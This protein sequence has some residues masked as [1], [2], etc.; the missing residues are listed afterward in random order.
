MKTS[1][2]SLIFT[3]TSF[4][5]LYAQVQQ[6]W[7]QRYNGPGNSEDR[8]NHIV[9]DLSGN[10]Y[11]TGFSIGSGTA[12]DIAT[13]KYNSA[14]VQQWV[15]RYNGQG[16]GWDV[17]Y[18]IAVDR[19]G[20]VY[21]TGASEGIGTFD[22]YVTI[23]YNSDG[24][25]QWVQ[26][27]NGPGNDWDHAYRIGLDLFGNVY[28]TGRSIGSGTD[29]DYATIKYNSDGVQQWV[30][31]YNGP[32]NS[33]DMAFSIAVHPLGDVFVTGTSVGSGTDY[34]YATIKYNSDGV[35]QWVQRYNGPGNGWDD[36]Y[37]IA[38]DRLGNVYVT[39][40]SIGSGTGWDV[41]TIKY[42]SNGVQ[43]WVQRYNGPGNG[44]DGAGSIA[45][46]P[47]GS[48]YVTGSSVGIGTG[49]DYNTIKYN[50]DGV[51]Q[52]VQ[53]YNGPGN[54][55]DNAFSIDLDPSGSVYVNG[56]S[57]GSGTGLD[58]ATIK[59]SSSGEEQWVERYNGPANDWDFGNN[60]AVHPSGDVYVAG[61]SA[62]IGTS[63]DYATIK[64][65]RVHGNYVV[66]INPESGEIPHEFK[67]YQNYPNPFN[68]ATK[69]RFDLP[70]NG[71]REMSNVKLIV[72]DILGREIA[73][74]VNEGMLP[75]TYEVDWD[76]ASY[77]S[78]VYFYKLTTESF[79]ETKSMMLIK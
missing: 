17:A 20:N 52:W 28:V 33:W 69:I 32:G 27:Y 42:N 58:Y 47:L 25:Q 7:V 34:D 37:G 60:I 40:R 19:L 2:L 4:F 21:V 26:T 59:Y 62:G 71:K 41:A 43:Q 11:V 24:V 48:V 74:L 56:A 14:G 5:T 49:F 30:Q 55:Q 35:Q 57:I 75:G 9:I 22:D 13:I 36:A 64:Y 66:G 45:V 16:S 63:L 44:W 73:T 53:R 39:G 77:P 76:A 46:N 65:S 61:M 3:I 72:Y 15:Q 70:S 78:G 8:A 67:L 23:K 51:Q 68:P 38:V 31:R 54:G 18:R 10:V 12:W 29:F 50:S 79:T 1:I 6:E